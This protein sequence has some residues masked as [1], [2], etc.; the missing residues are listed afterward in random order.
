MEK[1]ESGEPRK[2][3]NWGVLEHAPEAV[4]AVKKE[5]N[6]YYYELMG[7]IGIPTDNAMN[8]EQSIWQAVQNR[9]N[10]FEYHG[11]S[12]ELKKSDDETIFICSQNEII[13]E[14]VTNG[15][16]YDVEVREGKQAYIS[17][18]QPPNPIIIKDGKYQ[19]NAKDDKER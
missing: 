19:E 10:T 2:F 15:E 8:F 7:N 13:A 14:M 1:D 11:H 5:H 6:I 12:Y 9:N 4:F 18:V 3:Q 17:N 16:E